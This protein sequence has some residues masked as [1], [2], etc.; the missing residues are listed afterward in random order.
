MLHLLAG[1]LET[2]QHLVELLISLLADRPDLWQQL[3]EDHSLIG[4][5][6]EEMLRW[7]APFQ[8]SRRRPLK[9]VVIRGVSIRENSTVFAV[10]GAANRDDRVFPEPD[11]YQLNRDLTR[12]LAFGFGIHYCP[13]A[14]VTRAEVHALL[15]EML[16]R[17]SAVE[18][19]GPSEPWP[20]P[21]PM[22]TVE[23]MHGMK[24]L[25]VQLRHR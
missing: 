3:S 21:D 6:I 11:E 16:D 20:A 17:Y 1:G 7:D 9:D 19:A 25:P 10:I 4:P 14:P 23:T 5:A 8:A 2:T 12:P 22:L 13:G 15:A 18:R 24:R